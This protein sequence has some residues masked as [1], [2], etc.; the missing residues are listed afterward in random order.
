ML[1][2]YR[3]PTMHKPY[4]VTVALGRVLYQTRISQNLTQSEVAERAGLKQAQVSRIESSANP[5]T[6]ATLAKLS[7]A[8]GVPQSLLYLR[9]EQIADAVEALA[10]AH[11]ERVTAQAIHGAVDFYAAVLWE[12]TPPCTP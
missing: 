1:S 2:G 4:I 8:L 5:P 11:P 7:A 9:V 6:P 12:P 10:S 3:V